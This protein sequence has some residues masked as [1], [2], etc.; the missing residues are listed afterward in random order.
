[1]CVFVCSRIKKG[2]SRGGKCDVYLQLKYK[3][4][5]AEVQNVT[6]LKKN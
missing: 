1:M 2:K 4:A 3:K 6:Q 5:K